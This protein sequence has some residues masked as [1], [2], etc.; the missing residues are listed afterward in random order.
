MIV[1]TRATR[2]DGESGGEP[3]FSR[4]GELLFIGFGLWMIVGLF[5]D[6]WAHSEQRPDSF[7]T[8]WHGVLYSGF[9][10]AAGSAFI[11]LTQQRRLGRSWLDA[12]PSGYRTSMVGLV[13][14]G[15]GGVGDLVWHQAFGVEVNLAAL[16]SPTH[17]LL[18]VGGIL[19]LTG[20]F[21]TAWQTPVDSP[22]IT[23]LLPALVSLILATGMAL[24]FTFYLSPFGQTIVARFPGSATDLHDFSRPSA[25]GFVQLR[26]M[27]AIGGILL[28]TVL[29]M[30]PVLLVLVRWHPP[31]GS[32]LVYFAA[33]AI[34]EGAASEFRRWPLMLAVLGAG[35]VAEALARRSSIR[36]LAGVVPATLWLGYFAV[37]AVLYDV[38]WTAELWTG[39]VT[40]GAM[41]GLALSLIAVPPARPA[42]IPL[43]GGFS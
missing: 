14:F 24:F 29:V 40:L 42:E 13:L 22:S 17:L 38:G 39:A 28:T 18:M 36:V 1:Q 23:S 41:T 7:F 16:V 11:Q 33:V 26:E 43:S 21:R 37:T 32:L 4:R 35:I 9:A 6:G 20:P 8:P 27:W 31:V 10:G 34:F 25:A 5:L 19:A 15:M 2:A 30:V 3:R 12:V